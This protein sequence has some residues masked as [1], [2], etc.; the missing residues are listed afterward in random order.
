MVTTILFIYGTLK[1][2]M[3]NHSLL[4]NQVFLGEYRTVPGYRLID[5]GPYPGLI[6]DDNSTGT[7]LGEL[8]QVDDATLSK[9]DVF[10]DVPNLYQR[11]A[12]K[13][14]S[15]PDPVQTYFYVG[16]CSQAVDC[17]DVWPAPHSQR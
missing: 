13:I 16:D 2:G 9:L 7:A 1:R 3:R 6:A 12:V 5:L 14:A 17:G 11:R 10:E 8:W 15:Y 4:A